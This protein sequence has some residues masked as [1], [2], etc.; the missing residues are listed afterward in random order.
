MSVDRRRLRESATFPA[1]VLAEIHRAAEQGVYEIHK[2][3][4]R[5][6]LWIPGFYPVS[7]DGWVKVLKA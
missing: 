4:D 5:A 7:A 3:P 1:H 6:A 2:I